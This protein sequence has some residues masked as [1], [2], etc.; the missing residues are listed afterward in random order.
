MIHLV[1]MGYVYSTSESRPNV[2]F[3]Q[4]PF[5]KPDRTICGISL[6]PETVANHSTVF[7][8]DHPDGCAECL[9][10]RTSQL[11]DKVQPVLL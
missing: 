1:P 8:H 6:T 2:L 9:R 5:K 11:T 10:G 3:V 4:G 7:P